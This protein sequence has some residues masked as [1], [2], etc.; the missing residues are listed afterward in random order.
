MPSAVDKGILLLP[1]AFRT[2]S[3]NYVRNGPDEITARIR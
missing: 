2:V 1:L 3:D